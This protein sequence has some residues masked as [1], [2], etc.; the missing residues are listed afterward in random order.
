MPSTSKTRSRAA[1]RRRAEDRT[2]GARRA[3]PSLLDEHVLV[4]LDRV[5]ADLGE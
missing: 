1:L 4:A 3:R 5:E 2:Q